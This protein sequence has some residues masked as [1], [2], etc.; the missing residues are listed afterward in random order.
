MVAQCPDC[1]KRLEPFAVQC[2]S[3][4]W[5]LVE[6]APASSSAEPGFEVA[7]DLVLEQALRLVDQNDLDKAMQFTARAVAVA[8]T[9]AQ[10]GEATA[11]RGY[12]RLKQ[13]DANGAE[14]DCRAALN[15]GYADHRVHAWLAAALG[16]QNRWP[17][18][19]DEL[20][21]AAN[22]GHAD[23]RRYAGFQ[24]NY[25][26]RANEWYEKQLAA[27][28][29]SAGLWFGRGWVRLRCG[30]R[31][32][33]AD[34]LGRALELDPQNHRALL[35]LAL[36]ALHRREGRQAADLASRALAS[37]D[38]SLQREALECRA[39]AHV[40]L[41]HQVES[42]QDLKHLRRLA[43]GDPA[44]VIR[45]ARLRGELGDMTLALGDLRTLLDAQPDL[46]DAWW[47]KGQ[48]YARLGNHRTA[49]AR[50]G[51]ANRLRPNDARILVDLAQSQAAAG[52][53]EYALQTFS[54][55]RELDSQ[56]ADAWLGQARMHIAAQDFKAGLEAV[57]AA[58]SL[59]DHRA[60]S[61]GVRGQVRFG[62]CEY[63]EAI[64][65]FSRAIELA[66]DRLVKADLLYRRGTALH[67]QGEADKA[68]ADFVAASQL[69]PGNVGAWVW[70][71]AVHS[72]L[73]RWNET[74]ADLQ[75]VMRFR[76]DQA[77]AYLT[78]ARP[79][80]QRCVEHFTRR[81]QRTENPPASLYRNRGLAHEFLNN[82][83]QA[84]EDYGVVLEKERGEPFVTLRMARL[85]QQLGQHETAVSVLSRLIR[86]DR[87]NHAAR[88]ARA[89]SHLASGSTKNAMS[90][91]VKA[92][93]LAPEVSRYRLL[94]GE[95][96]QKLGETGRA[97]QDFNHAIWLDSNDPAGWR[98][99]AE[100]LL[101]TG[102]SEAAIRDLTRAIDLAGEPA[103]LLVRRGQAL[104]QADNPG[105]AIADFDKC[106]RQNP[107][108]LSAV[109]GRAMA[110]SGLG[111]FQEALIW[112]TKSLHRFAEVTD[113]ARV[114][115]ARGKVYYRMGSSACAVAD[116]TTVLHL[117]SGDAVAER[118]VRYARALASI[119]HGQFAAAERDLRKLLQAHPE[120]R[121]SKRIQ[122]WLAD[123][124]QAIPDELH[125]PAR[126]IRMDR[127]RVL[128][129]G[130]PVEASA[131]PWKAD[132]PWDTWVVR[133]DEDHEFGPIP[134]ST[135]DK[136]V[137]QGRI[138]A[139]MKLL[140][141]DWPRW[142]RAEKV[143]GQLEA[144]AAAR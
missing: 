37:A 80:A 135:L 54:R 112:L 104:L 33:A 117:V 97:I 92:I 27:N 139:G 106:I 122:T 3:C 75:Q 110:L 2:E 43:G 101:K 125:R 58:L 41:G 120:H 21:K 83:F 34:D 89:I 105:A 36:I 17:E 73:Q 98:L 118:T 6:S 48:L 142:K 72:R 77:R 66:S 39:R 22:G 4:G 141:G 9:D 12:I 15:S 127:P 64:D 121:P 38:A 63:R 40:L 49:I 126:I 93:K 44:L 1:K 29:G 96:R 91:A 25:L 111:R 94:R 24:L 136:W 130:I 114:L 68:L 7:F 56:S 137:E 116:F 5:S 82:V 55:A 79:V 31:K 90:D 78:L 134:K 16:Q 140:R 35:G 86:R 13:G 30:D 102:E 8:E 19:I 11:L 107:A 65:D 10:R 61:Y 95:L 42:R 62:L 45:H 18:A 57:T 99:R 53:T 131:D 119:Q 20:A 113:M 143:Y 26:Q 129:T 124:S 108:M 59:D 23:Q 81:L 103:D 67:E 71:A 138:E 28:A 70:R 87:A 76:S 88:Y 128:R 47:L 74:V 52:K 32:N 115:L 51:E 100:L 14:S 132:P 50:F 133:N 69:T 60:D 109:T 85:L 84:V 46:A 123:R 144:N